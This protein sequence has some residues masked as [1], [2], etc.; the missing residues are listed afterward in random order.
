MCGRDTLPAPLNVLRTKFGAEL[1]LPL[2]VWPLPR[3]IDNMRTALGCCL[4]LLAV[5]ALTGCERPSPRV[6]RLHPLETMTR[7]HAQEIENAVQATDNKLPPETDEAE[8]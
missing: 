8:R 7:E 2:D 1:Q 4:C 3:T 5:T 6:R